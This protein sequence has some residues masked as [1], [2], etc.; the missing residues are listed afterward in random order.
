MQPCK[1]YQKSPTAQ[2]SHHMH[3]GGD[4]RSCVYFSRFNC[5][6]HTNA[7]PADMLM[8]LNTF[9]FDG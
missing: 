3:P 7:N 6:T 1:K 4:C 5:G 8:S 2:A 9:V